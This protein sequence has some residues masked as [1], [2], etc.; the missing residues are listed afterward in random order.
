MNQ[1]PFDR[2]E[3]YVVY[4]C[5][6]WFGSQLNTYPKGENMELV[7]GSENVNKPL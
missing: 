7:F 5:V 1:K 6:K 3:N 4:Q 2:Q